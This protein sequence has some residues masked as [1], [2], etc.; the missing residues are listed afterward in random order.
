MMRFKLPTFL[1]MKS[2]QKTLLGITCVTR[3]IILK[4]DLQK[5][6]SGKD[7]VVRSCQHRTEISGPIKCGKYA[8]QLIFRRVFI[9]CFSHAFIKLA[10]L[11]SA[12]Q[13]LQATCTPWDDILSRYTVPNFMELNWV[14]GTWKW[15][16]HGQ[17][18]TIF[19]LCVLSEV[20]NRIWKYYY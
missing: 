17:P 10:N 14:L 12:V 13:R 15:M 16:T 20:K 7:L 2:E 3:R 18:D 19:S 1:L 8:E 6:V 5:L 9:K 4:R 11:V